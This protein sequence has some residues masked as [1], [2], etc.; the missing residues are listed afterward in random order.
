M[1]VSQFEYEDLTN[2]IVDKMLFEGI[3]DDELSGDCI[4]VFGSK[5]AIEYRV[6]KAVDL[7][8]RKRAKIVLMS[9]GKEIEL[10]GERVL[11]A[12]AMKKR[13]LELGLSE[14]D[15]V[16]EVFSEKS[17]KENILGSLIQLDRVLGLH[18]IR[19]VL[20]VT[21]LYHMKRCSLMAETYMPR[22]IQFSM[23]PANDNNTL[24]HN[25]FLT[26]QGT[27]RARNEAYK[28]VCYIKEGSLPDFNI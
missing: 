22:W 2:E 8:K 14:C 3:L 23:C 15:I 13:A 16:A 18:R 4:L 1:K 21:T 11:E 28:I 27:K 26:D 17:T 9:G 12:V 5:S 24:R 25:W 7:Y 6:P 20:L 10:D 19:R